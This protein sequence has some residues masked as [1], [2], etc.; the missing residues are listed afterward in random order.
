MT[1]HCRAAGPSVVHSDRRGTRSSGALLRAQLP[2]AAGGDRRRRGRLGDRRRRPPLPRL[3][4]RLLGAQLRPPPPRAHRRG[5]RAARPGHAHQPRVRQRPARPVLRRA[6]RAAR[7]GDGA[8][9]EHRRRGGRDRRSRSPA[10]GATRSR[11]CPT[12]RAAIVVAAGGFHGRTTTIVGFSTDPDARG[13]FG[14]FTPGFDVVPYGDARRAARPRSTT[15][16]V[17]VLLEPIQGEAGVIVPPPGY[18]AGVR[19]DLRRAPACCSSPTRSSRASAAPGTCWRRGHE[20]V[21]PDV[22]LLGKALG[23]GIVPVSAVVADADVLGVLRPGQHGSTFGG[24]PLACAV[25]GAVVDLLDDGDRAGAAPATSARSCTARLDGPASGTGCRGA[26]RRAV[27]RHRHRPA[28]GATAGP[29]A[30]RLRPAACWP[31]TRTARRS[32]S[33]RRWW[34]P[35]TSS[36]SPSTRSPT[37]SRTERS[38]RSDH[39]HGAELAERSS[40][41]SGAGRAIISAERSVRSDQ[42]RLT[43]DGNAVPYPIWRI[44]TTAGRLVLG[45]SAAPARG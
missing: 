17:A 37:C 32:G 4:G 1:A 8:A 15:D 45:G 34:S 12:D 7:Q 6:R 28:A 43:V 20:G 23:G 16:T 21:V 41:R 31:R 3:P 9:D 22:Y 13:G 5:P 2:P 44:R 35:A 25:G 36:T 39:R 11:A 40:T 26:R 30:K 10:S 18:L 14:P 38:L 29:S 42:R 33:P 19:R 24:N 27:G